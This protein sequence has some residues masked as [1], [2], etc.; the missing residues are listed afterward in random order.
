MAHAAHGS[1]SFAGRLHV[2]ARFRRALNWIIW[3]REA[4]AIRRIEQ[5]S[6]FLIGPSQLR[7]MKRHHLAHRP[8]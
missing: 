7:E 5:E 1:F 3:A 4:E 8:L 6:G 2:P